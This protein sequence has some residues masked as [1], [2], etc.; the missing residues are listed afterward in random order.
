[1]TEAFDRF[2]VT[3]DVNRCA[4]ADGVPLEGR[5]VVPHVLVDYDP[6]DLAA[7]RDT[8]LERAIQELA[9]E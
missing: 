1:M 3:V 6:V 7:G 9:V 5:S 4:D 8:V 2:S